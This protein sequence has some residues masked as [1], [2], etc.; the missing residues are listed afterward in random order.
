MSETTPVQQP[1]TYM[2]V[3]IYIY[4]QY[5]YMYVCV[6]AC[7]HACTR[8]HVE[9]CLYRYVSPFVRNLEL[10]PSCSPRRC[11]PG[12]WDASQQLGLIATACVGLDLLGCRSWGN[13]T[14]NSFVFWVA[15]WLC[16]LGSQSSSSHRQQ[17]GCHRR[18]GCDTPFVQHCVPTLSGQQH[19]HYGCEM[20]ALGFHWVW[21]TLVRLD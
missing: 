8:P 16:H 12:F 18:S 20:A 3:C 13:E 10:A 11:R 17:R 4:I 7:M 6:Q 2:H 19:G 1:S 9:M 21:T 14:R 15:A 5:V